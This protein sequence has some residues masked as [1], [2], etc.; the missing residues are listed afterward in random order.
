MAI[1]KAF[2]SKDAQLE[3]L[4]NQPSEFSIN[5]STERDDRLNQSA[6]SKKAT[7]Y[8]EGD[9]THTCNLM[10]GMADQAAIES[11]AKK[12]GYKS[13]L[14]LPPF[15]MVISFV[16]PDQQ[17]VQDVVTAK[18]K[19][20][21]RPVGISETIRYEHTMFVVDIEYNKSL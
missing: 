1:V 12:K 15:P 21:G 10:L 17:L 5:Y 14:D 2:D 11:A 18:F 7:S 19:S 20:T 16:N 3:M 4:G 9:E 8:S 6:G 13:I